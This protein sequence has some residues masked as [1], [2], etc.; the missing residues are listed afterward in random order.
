[1]IYQARPIIAL[2][3]LQFSQSNQEWKML[4]KKV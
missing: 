3:I 2:K 4:A 1:M